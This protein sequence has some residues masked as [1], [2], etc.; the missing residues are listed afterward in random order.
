MELIWLHQK[1]NYRVCLQCEKY[2]KPV[3]NSAVQDVTAGKTHYQGSHSGVFT[4]NSF[5]KKAIEL[6]ENN[7]VCSCIAMN[8]TTLKKYCPR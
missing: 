8:W 3:G 2:T 7:N 4:N 6:A 1:N 5:A